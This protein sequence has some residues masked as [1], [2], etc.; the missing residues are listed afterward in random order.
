MQVW[1][2]YLLALGAGIAVA[3]QQVLNGNLRSALNSPAWAGLISYLGGLVTM[4]VVLVATRE[5]VPS[6]KLVSAVPWWAWSG[7]ILGGVFILLMILLLP[8]L[9]AATLLAL[10]VAGQMTAGIAMDH[11][12]VFGLAQHPVSI[13]R[14]AGIALIIG[15]VLPIKD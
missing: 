15:G 1:F 2:L 14:L 9:G 5:P 13:S 3:V 12:G 10:V 7:G 11:F 4:A 8:S 6:W